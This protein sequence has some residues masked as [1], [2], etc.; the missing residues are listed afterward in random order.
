MA[1]HRPVDWLDR[2][3][4]RIVNQLS[5]QVRVG[6]QT[7]ASASHLIIKNAFSKE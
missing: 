3:S 6:L 1:D 7:L 4:C 2:S 5:S